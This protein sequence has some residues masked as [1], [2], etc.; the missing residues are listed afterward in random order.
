MAPL[1]PAMKTTTYAYDESGHRQ[2]TSTTM[3]DSEGKQIVTAHKYPTDYT[4]RTSAAL[5]RL[6]D[7][8]MLDRV[9]E[10]V[11]YRRERGAVP[12]DFRFAQPVRPVPGRAKTG[13]GL[14][15]RVRQ[16]ARYP[17]PH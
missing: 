9:V 4:Q 7:N 17:E 1:P 8:H 11:T 13:R 16:P 2:L 14:R 6:V 3:V 5:D 12:A 15:G 10:T